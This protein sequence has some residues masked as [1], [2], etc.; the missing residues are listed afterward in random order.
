MKLKNYIPRTEKRCCTCKIVK[1][2]DKF[3]NN[4]RSKDG[5]CT[6]CIECTDEKDKRYFFENYYENDHRCK[7][8]PNEY[9]SEF[10]R[11]AVFEIMEALGWIFNEKNGIWYKPGGWKTEDGKW[12]F[13]FKTY[14]ARELG[15]IKMKETKYGIK[16]KKQKARKLK[17]KNIEL[18]E[19]FKNLIPTEAW[20]SQKIRP[21]KLTIEEML[22]LRNEYINDENLTYSQMAK[23]YGI[24][25]SKVHEILHFKINKKKLK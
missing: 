14:T 20:L 21:G 18:K 3:Y 15:I 23:K 24:K 9:Y 19:Y 1:P 16:Q 12:N 7:P 4:K 6:E 25:I 5:K 10:E 13:P 11:N 17:N 2:L 22:T 8:N